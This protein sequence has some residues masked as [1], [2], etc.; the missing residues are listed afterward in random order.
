MPSLRGCCG[1]A[2]NSFISV[3]TQLIR[4]GL[5]LEFET[6]RSQSDTWL[7]IYGREKAK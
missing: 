5:N 4:L 2:V 3:F 6:F 7:L 1:V